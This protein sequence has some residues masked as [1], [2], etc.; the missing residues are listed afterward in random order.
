MIKHVIFDIGNVLVTFHPVSYFKKYFDE[1]TASF[2]CDEVFASEQWR[3]VD[4]GILSEGEAK[5]YF[6]KKL[7]S[8]TVQLQM[9]FDN[10]KGLMTLKEETYALLKKLRDNGY[11]L[12]ILSNIGEESYAYC[13]QHFPFF[14]DVK[15]GVF[16]Y[17]EKVVKPDPAIYECLLKRY[18]LLPGECIFF[19]D[20]PENVKAACKMGIHA[21]LFRDAAQAEKDLADIL[22]EEEYAES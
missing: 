8:Y 20:E 15:G 7:P 6:L 9:L 14:E 16:S 1:A 2:L 11:C 4:Q 21:V 19:D 12:Y 5:D 10:W 17:Q 22:A 13:I 18:K 3:F